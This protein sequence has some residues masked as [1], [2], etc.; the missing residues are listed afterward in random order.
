MFRL[1]I[2]IVAVLALALAPVTAWSQSFVRQANT[3]PAGFCQLTLS[4]SAAEI[5]TCTGG[6]PKG[7]RTALIRVE[8]ANARWRD[9]GTAPTTTAGMLMQTTDTFLL[10]YTGNLA[11]LQFIAVT[12]SPVLDISFYQ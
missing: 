2:K 4:G 8:T 3:P 1:A 11:A 9:D 10:D 5:S 12:G 6:I 7:A